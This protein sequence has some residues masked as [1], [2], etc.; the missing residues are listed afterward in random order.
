MVI[1]VPGFTSV[2]VVVLATNQFFSAVD[3]LVEIVTSPGVVP[4]NAGSAGSAIETATAKAAAARNLRL[5]PSVLVTVM[6]HL[7]F[8]LENYDQDVCVRACACVRACV[9]SVTLHVAIGLECVHRLTPLP[10]RQ[11]FGDVLGLDV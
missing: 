1:C 2:N 7:S 4:A 3:P 10:R 9:C 6:F 5:E 8:D 11:R